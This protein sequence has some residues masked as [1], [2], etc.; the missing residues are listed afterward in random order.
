MINKD[1]GASTASIRAMSQKAAHVLALS[2]MA[3]IAGRDEVAFRGHGNV[4]Q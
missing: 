2:R 3:L 1:A 4:D